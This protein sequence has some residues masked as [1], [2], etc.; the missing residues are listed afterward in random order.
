MAP[1]SKVLSNPILFKTVAEALKPDVGATKAMKDLAK[2]N[3]GSKSISGEEMAAA[4]TQG[5]ADPDNQAAG[6]EYAVI[7]QFV[8]KNPTKLSPEAKK[9]FEVYK[10]Q[11]ELSKTNGQTGIDPRAYSK[12]TAAMGQAAKPQY[13]DKSA[14]EQLTT[15]AKG[16]K[17]PGSISGKEMTDA[18]LKGT[19]DPD[20]Q[21]AGKEF[22]DIS[23]FVRENAQLL[24]PEAKAA[25]AVYEKAAHAAQAKGQTGIDDSSFRR[26]ARDMAKAGAPKYADEGMGKAL[27]ALA[28]K[29]S[30]PGS[31]SA[32]DLAAAVSSGAR[33]LD[34]QSAGKE[35]KDLQKFVRENAQLLS[36]DAKTAYAMYEKAAVTAQRAGSTSV[37]TLE[38]FDKLVK[39]MGNVGA[40]PAVVDPA[41]NV[42]RGQVDASAA[43]A[44]DELGRANPGPGSISGKEMAAAIKA[45]TQDLDNQA[46]GSEYKQIA[47][48]V[49]D[50]EGKLSPE[51][52]AAFAVYQKAAKAA[53]GA[54]ETG[55][56]LPAFNKM[57]QEME[58]AGQPKY[59]DAG[60]GEE[61]NK[62]GAA[63]TSPGS[64]TAKQ[65]S[66][67]ISK[68]ARDLDG[69][70]AGKEFED[71]AKFVAENQQ[72]LT[73]D[74]KAA[75]ALY[76]KAAMSAREKGSTSVG[77]LEQFDKLVKDMAAIGTSAPAP[78][79]GPTA[80]TAPSTT[81]RPSAATQ[82]A[83]QARQ[84]LGRL[85][86]PPMPSRSAS[87]AEQARYQKDLG[88]YNEVKNI[89]TSTIKTLDGLPNP[90]PAGLQAPKLPGMDFTPQQMIKFQGDLQKFAA[91][92]V[93]A[94]P[95]AGTELADQVRQA[96]GN[97][98]EPA[99]PGANASPAELAKFQADFQKFTQINGLLNQVVSSLDGLPKP[100]PAGLVAPRLP[101]ADATDGELAKF[102]ADVQKF[103]AAAKGSQAGS[104]APA[105]GTQTTPSAGTSTPAQVS[106]VGTIEDR[107]AAALGALTE[108]K[109]PGKDATE[110]ELAQ[111]QKDLGKYN[112]MYEMMSKVMAN[113][114]EMKKAL[115]GNLPR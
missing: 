56:P 92:A 26:M 102:A 38:Q 83:D 100:L 115:I 29:D 36:P 51:A 71:L 93:G 14:A 15:L 69:N 9:V 45:G 96:L 95:T 66:E 27:N 98:R 4:I 42:D 3:P 41:F 2:N 37:G 61:L 32:K 70:S 108:P 7:K 89:L 103:V 8:D 23:K 60:M 16:N 99:F 112:R 76:E 64:V 101:G 79:T 68:G 47:K 67:A 84:A 49:K 75:F 94:R 22:K 107:A 77:T 44:M 55:I 57:V 43:K 86:S 106:G 82:L 28:T 12:M 5:T 34:G 35:F 30:T 65:L 91:A 40:K 110:A 114:H 85:V 109:F 19:Q 1:I 48:F 73:P 50:N 59:Q 31:I 88:K 111:F 58:A 78:T 90:L 97:M 6:K 20:S 62:L 54:G 53:Q 46:A 21:A 25:Y 87:A 33:D 81:T 10:K 11:V 104:S 63:N 72:L 18:I 80:T 24:S 13:L 113:A 105:T 39:D 74:A 17:A 52:K